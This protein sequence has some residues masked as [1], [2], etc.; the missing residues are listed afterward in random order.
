MRHMR[1][2]GQVTREGDDDGHRRD[3]WGDISG[4]V[5]GDPKKLL[6]SI[7]GLIGNSAGLQN[8]VGTLSKS[9]L[10]SQVDS[11][12]GTGKNQA[13]DPQ[14]L[15]G[16]IGEDKVKA[17]A[18]QAG[19]SEEQAKTG[20]AAALPKLIDQLTPNGSVPTSGVG[21]II[22]GLEGMLGGKG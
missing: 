14:Q 5:G 19:V 6:G 7:G 3:R 21:S 18:Q 2:Y 22:S 13:V 10:A 12:V 4:A 8:L 9:G 20:L 15:A 17:V 1:R 11:W 16:A